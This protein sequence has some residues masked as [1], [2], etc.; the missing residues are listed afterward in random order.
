M[1]EKEINTEIISAINNILTECEA[2]LYSTVSL[3][4]D[5]EKTTGRCPQS[6]GIIGMMLIQRIYNPHPLQNE[7]P[8]CGCL[9]QNICGSSG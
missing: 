9:L 1:S 4:S 6:A 5:K 3:E 7:V 2:H 8:G